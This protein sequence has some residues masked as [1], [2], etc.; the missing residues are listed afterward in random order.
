MFYNKFKQGF[1]R[2]ILAYILIFIFL[3]VTVVLIIFD[4]NSA[5]ITVSVISFVFL[6]AAFI[7]DLFFADVFKFESDRFYTNKQPL[8]SIKYAP[9]LFRKVSVRYDTIYKLEKR[10]LDRTRFV[11][12]IS[13]KDEEPLQYV[14]THED[15]RDFIYDKLTE[16]MKI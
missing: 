4:D 5:R 10:I 12:I 7:Y 11:L 16:L 6:A 9:K 15:T 8:G 2:N 3:A 13:F 14:F 1:L